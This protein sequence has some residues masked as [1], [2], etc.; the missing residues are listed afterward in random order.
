MTTPVKPIGIQ[1]IENRLDVFDGLIDMDDLASR[2][3]Q[4]RAVFVSRAL[5][6][7][8]V[9]ILGNTDYA[10]AGHSVTDTF[11]DRGIDAIFFDA[12]LNRLLLVTSKWSD[13]IS[14]KDCGE[15]CDG[16]RKLVV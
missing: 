9:K 2:P 10:A 6:A 14:W 4:K 5:A 11:H 1:R 15:F 16:I 12:R 13:G 7:Y 3:Q 8:T